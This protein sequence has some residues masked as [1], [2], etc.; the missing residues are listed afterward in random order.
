MFEFSP[1]STPFSDFK[2]FTK[3]FHDDSINVVV[4]EIEN[5]ETNIGTTNEVPY[6]DFALEE[7]DCVQHMDA[8]EDIFSRY[9]IH[10][11]SNEQYTLYFHVDIIG[12]VVECDNNGHSECVLNTHFEGFL[13]KKIFE[14]FEHASE[15]SYTYFCDNM[16]TIDDLVCEP[17][18]ENI[19]C[20]EC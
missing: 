8:Y 7:C 5:V 17:E 16:A 15:S 2:Y 3:C 1:S 19:Y 12:G 14:S 4:H 6:Y 10:T 20:V 13:V 9:V 11:L 18:V